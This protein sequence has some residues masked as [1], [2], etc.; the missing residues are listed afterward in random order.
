MPQHMVN[1]DRH[2]PTFCKL[3][4]EEN[5]EH[6]VTICNFIGG[7]LFI[8]G[9]I[10]F[11]PFQSVNLFNPGCW[12]YF[13][14]CV[15]YFFVGLNDLTEMIQA[16]AHKKVG[17]YAYEV[18]AVSS[19]LSGT[20]LYLVGSIFFLSY[21]G[22]DLAGGWCFTVGSIALVGGSF[23]NLL[24]VYLLHNPQLLSLQNF[25]AVQQLLAAV[26]FLLPSIW[27]LP[28]NFP[29]QCRELPSGSRWVAS[30]QAALYL[31]GSTLF[32]T[33]A[34]TN[35]FRSRLFIVFKRIQKDAYPVEADNSMVNT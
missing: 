22:M 8:A 16:R 9:S 14:G 7:L 10:C 23:M 21:V 5:A 35:L 17:I 30:W 31:V 24:H 15:I 28:G 29:D 1:R 26:F 25:C 12:L 34:M 33:T 6:F 27:Y 3:V 20:T 11:F 18:I 19:N 2:F 32:T 4:G 13:C